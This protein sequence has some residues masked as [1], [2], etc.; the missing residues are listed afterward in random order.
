MPKNTDITL[1]ATFHN[2]GLIAHKTLLNIRQMI[3]RLRERES[4]RNYPES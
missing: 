2:E 4:L 1:I 3:S